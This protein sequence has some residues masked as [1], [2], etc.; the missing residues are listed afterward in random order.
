MEKTK[1]KQSSLVISK[2]LKQGREKV[3]FK[4]TSH[5]TVKAVLCFLFQFTKLF[6]GISPF[7][8][9]F[10]SS[11]FKPDGW[12]MSFIGSVLGLALSGRDGFW[13]YTL[14]LAGQTVIFALFDGALRRSLYKAIISSAVFLVLGFSALYVS[15]YIVYDV[16]ALILE[17]G[18]L[19]I[20]CIIFQVAENAFEG[21]N[22]RTVM[23]ET[24]YLCIYTMLMVFIMSLG[25]LG[26]FE[27]FAIAPVLSVLTVMVLSL[28]LGNIASL[29]AS[30]IF[31]LGAS[32]SHA[33]GYAVMATYPLAAL[34]GS[35]L[36]KYGKTGII[37]GFITAN[38]VS[39][40]FV[41]DT[42]EIALGIYECI[43]ASLIFLILPKKLT[44]TVS[45]LF[46]KASSS[47]EVNCSRI[48]TRSSVDGFYKI[49]C[50]IQDLSEIYKEND[51]EKK[52]SKTYLDMMKAGLVGKVCKGCTMKGI[53]VE[54]AQGVGSKTIESLLK[55]PLSSPAVS[56]EILPEDFRKSCHR[57]DSFSEAYNHFETIIKSEK[58]WLE[59]TSET[60][61]LVAH[62]LGGIAG[63]LK[64]ECVNALSSHDFELESRLW[65]ELDKYSVKAKDVEVKNSSIG[66]C[67]VTVTLASS[68]VS[69]ASK[70][71]IKVCIE[72]VCHTFFSFCGIRTNE[73]NYIFSF[74]PQSSYSAS[75]G[76]ATKAKTGEKVCGDSF[77]V[78]YTGKNRMV[79]VLSDGMGSGESAMSESKM[80]VELL[81]KFLG[82]GFD[83]ETSVNLINSS[84]LMQGRKECFSTMDICDINLESASVEFIKLAASNTLMLCGNET[85]RI[86]GEGLPLGILKDTSA[87]RYMLPISSDTVV[88]MMSD[89]IA[90]IELKNPGAKGWIEEELMNIKSKN[91]QIIAGKLLKKAS[92]IQGNK[93]C[94]D[95]TVLVGCIASTINAEEK[96]KL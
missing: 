3:L 15:N 86:Q 6:S 61:K 93:V 36:K 59:K 8:L 11:A 81:E 60:R 37:L 47:K 33:S 68:E 22:K 94:D 25:R 57:C 88:V 69:P 21:I 24:E 26:I 46:S 42:K 77:N 54:S 45:E 67:Y 65:T 50:S 92:K 38:C 1:N 34:F 43:F 55:R 72:N 35:S 4:F 29:P 13:V 19:G 18:L 96:V 78:I 30:V 9:A 40:V 27:R 17:A 7:G 49:A 76:Y 20:F 82:A 48:Q 23:S 5:E 28:S 53:C 80:T 85:K 58:K 39:S 75:F 44:E 51:K 95:M 62:Q 64:R 31:G 2:V 66:E 74:N 90:D 56:A 63:I 52:I 79:M 89:G 71:T 32:L 14:T 84:L 16:M 41:S 10:Y 73:G 70:D 91:P 12:V 87:K 83:C